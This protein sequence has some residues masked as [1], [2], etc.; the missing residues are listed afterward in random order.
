MKIIVQADNAKVKFPRLVKYDCG[1]YVILIKN[2]ETNPKKPKEFRGFVIHAG[3]G[4]CHGHNL[5]YSSEIWDDDCEI[6]MGSLT[7]QND[8]N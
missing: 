8:E 1:C 5:G 7:I 2:R 4:C 3:I 6:F